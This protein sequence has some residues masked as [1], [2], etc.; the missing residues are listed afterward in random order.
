MKKLLPT[1]EIIAIAARVSPSPADSPD[2][3]VMEAIS[4]LSGQVVHD[5]TNVLAGAMMDVS[6]V[7]AS[8]DKADDSVI[9]ALDN[10]A[11]I[12][13][14][15]RAFMER[16]TTLTDAGNLNLKDVHLVRHI[17]ET[18]A[19]FTEKTGNRWPV[20]TRVPEQHARAVFD[21]ARLSVIM[22]NLLAN[23]AEAMTEGGKILVSVEDMEVHDANRPSPSI[24][25]G[26]YMKIAV[27]DHGKGMS[28]E[29]Q[30][31]VF[32]PFFTTK[33]D[34]PGAGLGLTQVYFAVKSH[35]AKVRIETQTEESSFTRVEVY[36]PA[37]KNT[38][39]SASASEIKQPEISPEKPLTG[40]H[41]VIVDD[42]N[43]VMRA[44]DRLAG[45]KGASVMTYSD[46]QQA[47]A[48]LS[49]FPDGCVA[50]IDQKMPGMSGIDLAERIRSAR[51][52]VAIIMMSG[53]GIEGD[54]QKRIESAAI[55]GFLQ[56]PVDIPEFVQVIKSCAAR[57]SSSQ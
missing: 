53:Y 55:E 36:L 28:T 18:V 33:K 22:D 20:E 16:L 30:T 10:L 45:R 49:S 48:E 2:A 24:P 8:L 40:I 5:M 52:D 21:G 51:P 44:M 6:F 47:F 34:Q 56:K 1:P 11:D 4:R 29:D 43:I 42:E 14:K 3:A 39:V 17:R 32:H 46:P 37:D 19:A 27:Q 13:T 12:V 50:V 54:I 15:G 38:I 26:R 57:N 9:E 7:R 41:I 31:K 25:D 35:G 23:A